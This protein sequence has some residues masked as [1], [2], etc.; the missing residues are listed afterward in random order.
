MLELT[1][2]IVTAVIPLVVWLI[3]RR[4]ES[5][6]PPADIIKKYED[7]ARKAIAARDV[8]SV[9][10]L[11]DERLRAIDRNT[12]GQRGGLSE[13]KPTKPKRGLSGSRGKNA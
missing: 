10:A 3:R 4:V 6:D 7:E 13:A 8:V 2:V 5:S 12:S 9:N 1:I 11:L